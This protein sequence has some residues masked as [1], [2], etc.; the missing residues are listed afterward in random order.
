MINSFIFILLYFEYIIFY[1]IKN[2]FIELNKLIKMS[3]IEATNLLFS[4]K[5]VK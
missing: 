2:D 5:L 3:T 1:F 4:Y